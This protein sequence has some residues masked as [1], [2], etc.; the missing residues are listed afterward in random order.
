MVLNLPTCLNPTP[1]SIPFEDPTPFPL[2]LLI[3]RSNPVVAATHRH[4][5]HSTWVRA[6][7][8]ESGLARSNSRAKRTPVL[9]NPPDKTGHREASHG[10]RL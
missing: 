1:C 4:R 9:S 10:R 2:P 5:C 3:N 8:R 7:S 6:T